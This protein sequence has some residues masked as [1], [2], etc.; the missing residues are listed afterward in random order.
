MRSLP[1]LVETASPCR[2]RTPRLRASSGLLASS[3]KRAHS[4]RSNACRPRRGV[5]GLGH[6]PLAVQDVTLGGPPPI[7]EDAPEQQE[8]LALERVAAH[9]RRVLE[10][11]DQRV[12]VDLVA[13]E[14]ELA[15]L[16]DRVGP[17]VRLGGSYAPSRLAARRWGG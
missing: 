7:G 16:A 15:R 13:L 9:H 4:P 5:V 2:A 3:Q 17:A 12:Y 10:L 1:S 8:R 14:H 6:L 11:D